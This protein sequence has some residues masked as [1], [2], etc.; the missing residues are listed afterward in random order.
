[1][2]FIR[3]VTSYACIRVPLHVGVRAREIWLDLASLLREE[4]TVRYGTDRAVSLEYL[5]GG[6]HILFR[7]AG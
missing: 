6:G 5:G 2:R 3:R 7:R 1:M 4:G